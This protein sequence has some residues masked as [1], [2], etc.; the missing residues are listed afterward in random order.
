MKGT[1]LGEFEE[2]VLLTIG[3]LQDDAYGVAIKLEIEARTSRTPSIGALHSALSRLE[4]KGFIASKEGGATQAR[5][6]RR[7]RFYTITAAGK[8]TLVKANRLRNEL[9]NLIPN[10]STE[11]LN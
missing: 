1:Y 2:I 7:K 3:V 5:G 11:G 9:F 4:D 6:G 8:S 10:L